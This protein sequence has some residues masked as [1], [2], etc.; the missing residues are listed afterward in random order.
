MSLTAL[1][2]K[3]EKSDQPSRELDLEVLCATTKRPWKWH[4]SFPAETVVSWDKYGPDASGN[5]VCSLE[6]FT[7]SLDA[8]M[9]LIPDG[10]Q[11][12]IEVDAVWI[13]WLTRKDVSEVQSVMCGRGGAATARAMVAACLKAK[14]ALGRAH[15]LPISNGERQ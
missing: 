6:P 3:I 8:A 9:S 10:T 7:S 14:S 13:R 15:R 12:T 5:P 4:Q 11:W 1:A 2:D